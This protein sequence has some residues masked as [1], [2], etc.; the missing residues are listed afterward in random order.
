[1]VIRT[2]PTSSLEGHP[3]PP[4]SDR[5]RRAP[6]LQGACAN[7]HAMSAI[8]SLDLPNPAFAPERA[9]ELVREHWG[10]VP[11]L[12]EVGSTQDQNIRATAP[13]GRQFVL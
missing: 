4:A 1:M 6:P 9:A 2:I 11:R 3:V 13:D 10:F 5:I 7:M 8:E 12:A